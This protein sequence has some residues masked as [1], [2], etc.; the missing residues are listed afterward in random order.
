MTSIRVG[1]SAP[2]EVAIFVNGEPVIWQ[3]F[4][5]SGAPWQSE[6]DAREWADAL[7]AENISLGVWPPLAE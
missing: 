5:T 3:P 2:F 4:S 6:A 7:A 1:D